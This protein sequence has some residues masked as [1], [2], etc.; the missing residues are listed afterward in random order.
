MLGSLIS[1][2]LGVGHCHAFAPEFATVA[3]R[4]EGRVKCGK[5]NCDVERVVCQQAG[6][7]AY[8]TVQWYRPSSRQN[9]R[10]GDHHSA[11]RQNRQLCPRTS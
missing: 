7:S 1:M 4:L 11:S 6:V 8:P 2:L 5:V 9:S 10:P 3:Q